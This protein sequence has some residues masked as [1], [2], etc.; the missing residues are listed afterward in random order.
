MRKRIGGNAADRRHL[1]G[2]ELLDVLGEGFEVC[3]LRLDVLPVVKPF[4]HD[5]VEN[6][7]E[8]R[9]VGAGL[10]LQHVG[11]V[12]LERLA[13]RIHDDELRAA[14]GRLLEEGGGDRMVL[15]RIGADD[16]DDV[17]ILA[18]VE[19]GGDRRRA[20]RLEKR[21]NRGG[22]AQSRAVIDVVGAEAGAHE[23]L[24]EISLLVRG[25]G[26][27]E[28]G[29]R[30]RAIAIA[31]RFQSRGGAVERLLPGGGAEMRPGI[32]GI[33]GVVGVL[34]YAVLANERLR[35]AVRVAHIVEAEAAFD[36]EPVLVRGPVAAADVEELVVLDVIGELAAHPAIGAHAVDLAVRELGAHVRLIDD[37]RGHQRTGRASLHAF[38]A[39]D[40]GRV[41]HR[42][43][44]IE[45]DL[46]AE[47]A[48]GHADHVVDLHL[49]AG[50]D[51]QIALDAGVEIDRHR[52]VAAVRNGRRAARKPARR[53]VLPFRGQPELRL[54]IVR[55]VLRRLIGQQ[56][57]DNHPARGFCTVTLRLDLHAGR[58]GADAACRQ[59]AFAFDLHHADAAVAVG[60]IAGLRRVAQVRQL[61]AE[62]AR[63]A[64]DRL[65][66]ADV[67]L[68]T[69]DAEG[70]G[71]AADFG[72]HCDRLC[73]CRPGQASG[74]SASR[75]P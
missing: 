51:A 72:T 9:D 68:A 58:R 2:R 71:L 56:Q 33:D 37:G 18:L 32:G 21:R 44:E 31:D 61:D 38:A 29:E 34:G 17:G 35:E 66:G 30:L 1:L 40:A 73:A 43:V 62:A 4:G 70:V 59:H 28:A 60:A 8:H 3:G 25:L 49:A 23:F 5:R 45:H 24:E 19:G 10:E 6:A 7:V 42:V 67:D 46:L 75:D 50:A 69:I 36:A 63:G 11:G 15:G 27:A 48:A 64:E 47:A 16:D 20:D 55:Y 41:P 22:V 39:G 74:A 53:D 14:L 65:A 13:A 26:R 12:A 54:R 57:L 52:R